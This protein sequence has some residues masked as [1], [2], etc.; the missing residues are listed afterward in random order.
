[1]STYDDFFA[2]MKVMASAAG[3]KAGD[4]IEISKLKFA[5]ISLQSDIKR[6]YEKLGSTIY[7]MMKSDEEDPALI[8]EMIK[9][10]DE[11]IARKQE[12]AQKSADVKSRF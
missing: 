6:A 3:K 10:I 12:T 2:R 8:A 5:E 7:R 4:A 9:S 1:M 11:L